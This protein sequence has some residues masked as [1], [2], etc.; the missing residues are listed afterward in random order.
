MARML[1]PRMDFEFTPWR[2]LWSDWRFPS[3]FY[4]EGPDWTPPTDIAETDKSFVVSMELPGIDM[5]KTDISY[6]DGILTVK[7]EKH[8]ESSEGECC[9]CAERYE[10]S[11]SRTFRVSGKVE[12]DKIDATYKDG[13]L[14]VTLPKSEETMPKKIEVH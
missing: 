14:K 6:S 12:T 8:K 11:F 3:T 4:A 5:S 1:I 2:S 10:G 7:G 13:I 9:H